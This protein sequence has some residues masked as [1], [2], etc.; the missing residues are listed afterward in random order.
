MKLRCPWFVLLWMV[1]SVAFA[2]EQD[3]RLAEDA[4]KKP[5]A[6]VEVL[7][8]EQLPTLPDEHGFAGAFCGVSGE[9]LIVAGGANFPGGR[10]WD[11]AQ[12]VWHDRIFVLP[13]VEE[14]KGPEIIIVS[15]KEKHE[16]EK[17]TVVE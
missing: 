11:G 3:G 2:A 16:T 15:K 8:W 9:A 12:K 5:T 6:R 17:N 4:D 1:P 10:P 7:E 14:K 13:K